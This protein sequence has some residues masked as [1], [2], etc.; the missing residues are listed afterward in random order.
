MI[1]FVSLLGLLIAAW[2]M[3][4]HIGLYRTGKRKKS[5]PGGASQPVSTEKSDVETE[6]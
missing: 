1:L 6:V 5:A 4:H 3:A 2:G